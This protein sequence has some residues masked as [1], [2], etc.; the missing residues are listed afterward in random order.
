MVRSPRSF[1]RKDASCPPLDSP[2]PI[3]SL[4]PHNPR[5][6]P[7][8]N[9][10]FLLITRA[11][12]GFYAEIGP[13]MQES[14]FWPKVSIFLGPSTLR[15]IIVSPI[16]LYVVIR[17]DFRIKP[18]IALLAPV[19]QDSKHGQ[20]NPLDKSF[21]LRSTNFGRAAI[22]ASSFAPNVHI[23]YSTADFFSSGVPTN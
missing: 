3:Q 7:R 20:D 13:D 5:L 22:R 11:E 1:Q 16:S 9:P 2:L 17:I 19:R 23:E 21:A 15:S 10:P 6:R 8:L 4:I 14:C 12:S 18:L